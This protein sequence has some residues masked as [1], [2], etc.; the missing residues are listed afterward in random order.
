MKKLITIIIFMGIIAIVTSQT[1]IIR[2]LKTAFLGT[3]YAVGDLLVDWGVPEGSP[4]FSFNNFAP[5]DD[6]EHT[7]NVSNGA[8]SSRKVGVRGIK[9]NET[10][11]LSSVLDITISENGTTLYGPKSM[12][13]F[14]TDS[15]DIN[16]IELS[17]IPSSDNRDYQFSVTFAQNADNEFQGKTL[18][19]DLQIGVVSDDIPQACQGIDFG[20]R[21]PI[22]GTDGNDRINGTSRNDLIITFEGDDVVNGRGGNDCIVT[23]IGSDIA[24][25]GSGHD[26]LVGGEGQDRLH[27]GNGNDQL[28]GEEDN[29]TLYGNNGNDIID[30]GSGNDTVNGGNNNDTIHAGNGNDD[31]NAG[32]G[33]DIV[34][35]ENGL[36]NMRGG[37]GNDLLDGGNDLDAANGQNGQ[38]TCNAENE[39]NC[40]L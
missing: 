17:T 15:Q 7:V 33:N 12:L 23:G 24:R 22:L 31:V 5:G 1:D 11:N 19:F 25:G 37:N 4:I 35:G 14:F 18:V 21:P 29:D 32:N 39:L 30:A 40:E 34:F 36:D 38:D 6:E 16:G 28:F 3:A 26:I 10:G 9:T 27:G 20:S 8:A 13:E 2:N